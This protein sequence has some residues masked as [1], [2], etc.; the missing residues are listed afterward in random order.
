MLVLNVEPQW[1]SPYVFSCFVALKEK[2]VAF[3]TRVLDAEKGETRTREYLARTITGR[4]PTLFAGD[5]ALGESMA[6][7]EYLDEAFPEP[8]IL[9]IAE[10][11]RARCRQLMSWLRSDDTLPIR[12]ER[13]TSTMFYARA[14]R[15]LSKEAAAAASKLGEVAERVLPASEGDL[16]GAWSVADADLAFMIHRLILNGDEVGPRVRRWAEA[17]WERPSIQEFVHLPRG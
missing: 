8:P 11:S 6:I 1:V 17:A 15:P 14:D 13:P 2:K 4:V 3:E 9:P 10:R 16:F 12:I 5:F 7:V